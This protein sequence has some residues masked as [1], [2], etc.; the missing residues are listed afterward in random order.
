METTTFLFYD[1]IFRFEF[2]LITEK[3]GDDMYLCKIPKFNLIY[4]SKESEIKDLAFFMVRCW[5]K[6][7]ILE[8]APEMLSLL[9]KSKGTVL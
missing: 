4:S 7:Q 1:E 6:D 2:D 3:K 8:K 9:S 5:L